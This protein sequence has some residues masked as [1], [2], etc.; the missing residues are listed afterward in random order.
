MQLMYTEITYERKGWMSHD[1]LQHALKY[2]EWHTK[3]KPHSRALNMY[4]NKLPVLIKARVI[5]IL[6]NQNKRQFKES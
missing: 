6:V 4:K 1:A 3:W 2:C 5:G